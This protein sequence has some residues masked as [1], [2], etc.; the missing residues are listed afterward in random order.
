[1]LG[2]GLHWYVPH[3]IRV[4]L[5]TNIV[6]IFL[7]VVWTFS[8]DVGS[9]LPSSCE[10]FAEDPCVTFYAMS[11][12]WRVYRY[13]ISTLYSLATATTV[14]ANPDMVIQGAIL[15]DAWAIL[16]LSNSII[17]RCHFLGEVLGEV[18]DGVLI[19]LNILALGCS[20][21]VIL[22]VLIVIH[23]KFIDLNWIWL[24]LLIVK[25][26]NPWSHKQSISLTLRI[27]SSRVWERM[28]RWQW[29]NHVRPL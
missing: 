26:F 20:K 4:T 3:C 17:E 24:L 15:P 21:W 13:H 29:V 7:T 22:L 10:V 12:M 14:I 9:V 8:I 5:N 28:P 25:I 16:T 23:F 19:E 27:Q 6:N 2:G 18:L 1:M 11:H